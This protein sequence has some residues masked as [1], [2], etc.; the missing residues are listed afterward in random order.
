MLPYCVVFICM[1]ESCD[2]KSIHRFFDK[3]TLTF[4]HRMEIQ[5][6]DS[7]K[8]LQ[9]ITDSLVDFSSQRRMVI[10]TKKTYLMKF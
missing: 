8:T 4:D 1:C 9:A 10:N 6:Y 3:I 2:K 7:A 5:I